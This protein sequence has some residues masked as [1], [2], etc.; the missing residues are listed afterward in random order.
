MPTKQDQRPTCAAT[1]RDGQPCTSPALPGS[2]FCFG[3]DPAL[4]RKRRAGQAAGGRNRAKTAR[5]AKLVPE[6]LRPVLATLL[7]ALDEVH[8]GD[9]EPKAAS[10][11]AALAGAI[12]RVYSAGTLEERI[13]ALEA[14]QAEAEQ[15]A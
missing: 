10:A 14:A 4:A 8:D 1:R 2:R 13:A 7:D 9:L 15:T 3:H 12:V 5:L 6:T 11:M